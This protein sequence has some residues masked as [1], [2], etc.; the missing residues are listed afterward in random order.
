MSYS[1]AFWRRDLSTPLLLSGVMLDVER[2]SWMAVGGCDL[3]S[4][5]ASGGEAALWELA[6]LLRCRVEIADEQGRPAWW[7]YVDDVA[8]TIGALKWGVSLTT[9]ANRIQVAYEDVTAASTGTR[10]TTD[11]AQDDDSVDEY[12]TFDRQ[13]PLSSAGLDEAESRR[14]ALLE[15]LRYPQPTIDFTG[16]SVGAAVQCRGWWHSLKRRQYDNPGDGL[17]ETTDQIVDIITDVGE[18]FAGVEIETVSGIDSVEY[19]DGDTN[20]LAEVEDILAAGVADGRRYLATVSRERRVYVYE[21]PAPA[22]S[23]LH[24]LADGTVQDRW[25]NPMTYGPDVVGKWAILKDVVPAHVNMSRLA[26]ASRV[27]LERV[28]YD[29]AKNRLRPQPR[30]PSAYK[31]SKVVAG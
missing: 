8:I 23:D 14:D 9:M 24:M 19:R 21:E 29:A 11:W 30:G 27:F 15:A 20:A 16:S 3:A 5:Q 13:E 2:L 25:G 26:D 18:H 28:E 4:I 17:V 12:G 6:D 10:G 31:V 22:A 7:G 1:L